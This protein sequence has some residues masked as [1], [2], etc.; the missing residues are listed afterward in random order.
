MNV[1]ALSHVRT[2]RARSG[3]FKATMGPRN[4]IRDFIGVTH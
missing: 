1:L 4:K 2:A 3:A